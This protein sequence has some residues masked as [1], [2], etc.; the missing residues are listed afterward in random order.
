LRWNQLIERT[1]FGTAIVQQPPRQPDAEVHTLAACVR[2]D[3]G[4]SLHAV[5]V[6][7]VDLMGEQFFEL[8]R[9][10]VEQ[11]RFD[12]VTF[13]LNA[14]DELAGDR[15]FIALR[16]RRPRHRTLE[17]LE[18]RTRVYEQQRV[19]Q[20]EEAEATAA[21]RLAEA[22]ARLEAAVR[23]LERRTD[24]DERTREIMIQNLRSAEER[25][26]Q[27]ARANIEDERN[28]QVENARI[29]M[30]ASVRRIQNTV[31]LLAVALP[32]VPAFA[33]FLLVSARKLR[34]ERLRLARERLIV[35]QLT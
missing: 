7:D 15:S 1:L 32:P 10:G 22:Q 30:E 26:L 34:R 23:E 11:L 28:R 12:N 5:V 24:L 19:K 14:V 29:A 6:A 9:R 27:V 25:R 21:V 16:K 17:A 35:R 2:R 8:R 3:G 33:I 18:A 31:K 4:R 20:T 13:L